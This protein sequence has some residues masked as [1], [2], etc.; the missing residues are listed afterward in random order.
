MPFS[1]IYGSKIVWELIAQGADVNAQTKGGETPLHK[2]VKCGDLSLVRFLLGCG[3]DATIESG[4]GCTPVHMS[5]LDRDP[6][7]ASELAK[8]VEEPDI[9]VA[10]ALGRVRLMHTIL[11]NNLQAAR[12]AGP[13]FNMNALH[14][15]AIRGQRNAVE[16]L[17]REGAPIDSR[18]ALGRTPL[19]CA[20]LNDNVSCAKL[21]IFNE[22]PLNVRT[23]CEG[24]SIRKLTPLQQAA[25]AASKRTAE[26][27]AAESGWD[28]LSAAAL[29]KTNEL[30]AMLA[31][32][33]ALAAGNVDKTGVT[34]LHAASKSGELETVRLLLQKGVSS[35]AKDTSGRT[36]LQAATAHGRAGVVRVLLQAGADPDRSDTNGKSGLHVAAEEGYAEV[37]SILLKFGADPSKTYHGASSLFVAAR[38]GNVEVVQ[39]LLAAGVSANGIPK[40]KVPPLYSAIKWGHMEVVKE[41][42][43][44]GAD[45]NAC[46]LNGWR[47]LD[48][49]LRYDR[50]AIARYLLRRG[51]V[52]GADDSK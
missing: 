14:F 22:A 42:V 20:A 37:V 10:A 19:H 36:A 50:G 21:L 38:R 35:G 28:A 51:A 27:I 24:C 48:E 12:Q 32:D 16:L 25:L 33:S 6:R 41:L 47:P 39:V 44:A 45:V 2:A 5:L 46:F 4:T 29:G 34:P 8:H 11:K 40:G 1:P 52:L 31:K 23:G 26:A 13:L 15:A 18:D 43:A 9:Y 7:I 17:I 3:A 49:A 30:A